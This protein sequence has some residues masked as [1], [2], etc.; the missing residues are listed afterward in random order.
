M[1]SD[2]YCFR[3]LS[4]LESRWQESVMISDVCDIIRKHASKN[5]QC[6]VHYCS[7]Q[8]FQDRAVTALK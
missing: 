7:N 4:D 5:F 2:V 6:Y 3:F 8:T 1:I